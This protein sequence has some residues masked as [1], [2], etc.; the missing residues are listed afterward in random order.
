[1]K[2]VFTISAGVV[3][4]AA[5]QSTPVMAGPVVTPASFCDTTA[6]YVPNAAGLSVTDVTLA[7]S[8]ATNCF[9]MVGDNNSGNTDINAVA[10][11]SLLFGGTDC[12]HRDQG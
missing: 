4:A 9:G 2:K 10:E 6:P 5:L 11:G 12:G 7:G 3:L 8:N 1:M